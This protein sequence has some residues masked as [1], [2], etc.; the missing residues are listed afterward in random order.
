MMK[1]SAR[2]LCLLLVV[3][4]MI[5][6]FVSGWQL[7]RHSG[8]T[9][10]PIHRAYSDVNGGLKI[11]LQMLREDCGRFP[12]A[13]EGLKVLIAPPADGSLTNWRG[14]YIDL[15][16]VPRDS[17]GHEYVYHFPAIHSTNAYDLYSLGPDGISKSGGNDPDDICNWEKPPSAPLAQVYHE[18]NLM[19]L[20]PYLL[21]L[22]PI[23][24]G[25]RVVAGIFSPTFRAVM[26]ENASADTVWL[27]MALTSAIVWLMTFPQLAGR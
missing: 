18:N 24:Y 23:L 19:E 27:V 8:S 15:P 1:K 16:K 13:T 20:F 14:P 6:V 4:A 17:W 26:S 11:T 21:W 12:T 5:L 2:Y 10:A 7:T 25:A 9:D 22:I 3:Q